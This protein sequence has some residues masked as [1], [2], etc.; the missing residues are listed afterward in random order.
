MSLV[1]ADPLPPLYAHR[2]G[3]A[4]VGA[5][6]SSRAAFNGLLD[7]GR[8]D[9]VE[10]DC[11]MTAD[12]ELAL[13]HWGLLQLETDLAGWV[14]DTPASD[15]RAAYLKGADGSLTGEHVVFAE[16]F[17]SIIKSDPR[18]SGLRVLFEIKSYTDSEIARRTSARA[19]ELICE[20]GLESRVEIMS[21]WIEACIEAA[22]RGLTARF[23][24]HANH[25]AADLIRVLGNTGVGGIDYKHFMITTD[26]LQLFREARVSVTTFL[27][28]P[29]IAL[30][31][32][33]LAFRLDAINTERPIALR[34]RF[35]EDAL[36]S[37]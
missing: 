33:H 9:G 26:R 16:E 20:Y 23:I 13:V 6:S 14:H 27:A 21:Y 5:P 3:A 30:L 1:V 35:E 19:C 11:S 10:T 2:L 29:P 24:T 18:A 7:L 36:C 28:N 22:S 32:H 37:K 17:L 34:Q 12:G 4:E 8:V 25:D 15:L 31:R